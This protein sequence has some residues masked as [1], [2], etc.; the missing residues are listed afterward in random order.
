MPE[1]PEVPPR[2]FHVYSF[3]ILAF[4]LFYKDSF[5]YKETMRAPCETSGV[6]AVN[7][8]VF[9]QKCKKLDE[10]VC[11]RR[12]EGGEEDLG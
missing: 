8:L 1:A 3:L 7:H 9:L 12:P 10:Q 4:Y 6:W 11:K 2:G 5:T